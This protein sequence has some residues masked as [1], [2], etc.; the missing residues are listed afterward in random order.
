MEYLGLVWVGL[1]FLPWGSISYSCCGNLQEVVTGR[2]ALHRGLAGKLKQTHTFESDGLTIT[3]CN[4]WMIL[5]C[6]LS[7]LWVLVCVNKTYSSQNCFCCPLLCVNQSLQTGWV[8]VHWWQTQKGTYN[9]KFNIS[10]STNMPRMTF[11][12]MFFSSLLSYLP[13]LYGTCTPCLYKCFSPFPPLLQK[14]S[15]STHL[16]HHLQ[17]THR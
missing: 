13:R 14:T 2:A 6:R 8:F 3:C 4:L 12:T 11:N 17:Q 16:M 10:Q 1:V 7:A 15:L 9:L 5:E